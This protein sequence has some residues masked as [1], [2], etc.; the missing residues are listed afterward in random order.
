[1]SRRGNFS[2]IREILLYNTRRFISDPKSR[3]QRLAKLI[4]LGP[5]L[6]AVGSRSAE[7]VINPERLTATTVWVG[8]AQSDDFEGGYLDVRMYTIP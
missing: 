2:S 1:M 5:A 7:L 4:L 6:D 3:M 8:V